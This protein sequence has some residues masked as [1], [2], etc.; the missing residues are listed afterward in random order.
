[1]AEL[2]AAPNGREAL[3]TIFRYFS[4]VPDFSMIDTL[5]EALESTKPGVKDATTTMAE[6]WQAEGEA[7]HLRPHP[8]KFTPRA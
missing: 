1:M 3:W 8:W 7:R 2:L 4:S 5:R 6:R